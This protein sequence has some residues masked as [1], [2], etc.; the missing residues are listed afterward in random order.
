[1]TMILVSRIT[2]DSAPPDVAQTLARMHVPLPQSLPSY[3][4]IVRRRESTVQ[5]NGPG[6]HRVDSAGIGYVTHI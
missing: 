4:P 3:P 6:L 5:R 2:R 1:M